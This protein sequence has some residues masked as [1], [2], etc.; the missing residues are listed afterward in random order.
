MKYSNPKPPEGI[1]TGHHRPVREFVVL[2]GALVAV[3]GVVLVVAFRFGEW[4]APYVP[5]AWERKIEAPF[6]STFEDDGE[7]RP[8]VE[9]A[10]QNLADQLSTHMA[11]DEDIVITVRFVN[12]EQ[13]NAL[14][15]IGGNIFIYRGLLERLKTEEALATVL[16]HEIA[17][18]K[19]RDVLSSLTGGVLVSV[20]SALLL[21][22]GGAAA[23]LVGY[24][25]MLA[26]LNF[27]RDKERR[28]DR[29]AL[30]AVVELYGQGGGAVELFN[31]FQALEAEVGRSRTTDLLTSH[32][33]N[34]DRIEALESIA[35]QRSWSM[36]QPRRELPG[37]LKFD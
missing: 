34:K 13:V 12:D 37:V 10:L 6:V 29:D 14:A 1:N 7:P 18:V 19:H 17:H 22:D 20:A 28:A 26:T 9:L 33:L 36:E 11:L 30:A 4:V 2:T 27:S 16:A 24:E 21:G 31:V 15:T 3:V 32:P 5:F 25:T 35:H 8:D 23:D